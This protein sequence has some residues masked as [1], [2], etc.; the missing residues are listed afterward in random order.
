MDEGVNNFINSRPQRLCHK[1][2]DCCR[3]STTPIPY[4][5]LKK[6]VSQDDEN[7]KDFL[8]IFE[9]YESI[10]AASNVNKKIV[11]NIINALKRGEIFDEKNITFYKCKYI[12]DNNLCGIYENRKELCDR[13]PS[14]PWAIIPPGCGFEGWIFQKKEELK[15]KVR[16]QK[17]NLLIAETLLLKAKTT[18]QQEDIKTT[19][20]NIKN[21]I[22]AY[23]K[24]GADNW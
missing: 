10:E 19:I 9:P 18:K 17:E 12:L 24:Y 20:K 11:D 7:A 1:C 14:S 23:A 3:V 21:T 4:E 13:F 6:L 22:N 2:G 16:K 15:Q 8:E 5:E